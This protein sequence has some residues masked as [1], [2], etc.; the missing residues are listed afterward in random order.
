MALRVGIDGW[1]NRHQPEKQARIIKWSRVWSAPGKWG[2]LKTRGIWP[3]LTLRKM[4]KLNCYAL[5]SQF[6]ENSFIA[7]A[8]LA[9]SITAKRVAFYGPR[10]TGTTSGGTG[11][12]HL[13]K[14]GARKGETVAANSASPQAELG[15]FLGCLSPS[16]PPVFR[17]NR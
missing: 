11:H 15:E 2:K 10:R 4:G 13:R 8:A 5:C 14:K 17:I 9:W 3:A 6:Y 16:G 12:I 1:G 7:G